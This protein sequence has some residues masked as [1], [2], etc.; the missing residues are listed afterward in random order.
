MVNAEIF[1]PDHIIAAAAEITK[2]DLEDA[3]RA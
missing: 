2:Q 3:T 1:Q